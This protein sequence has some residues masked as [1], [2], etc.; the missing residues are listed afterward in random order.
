MN[1]YGRREN[2]DTEDLIPLAYNVI[3]EY[4]HTLVNFFFFGTSKFSNFFEVH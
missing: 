2:F 1:W 3:G 4:L